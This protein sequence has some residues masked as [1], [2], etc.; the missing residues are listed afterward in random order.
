VV[1]KAAKLMGRLAMEGQFNFIRSIWKFNKVYNADRQFADHQNKVVYQ[2]RP[3]VPHAPLS[4][5]RSEL[6]I[7][8]K[9][10]R[11]GGAEAAVPG[12]A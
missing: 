10:R 7:H 2:I 9:A 6:Y 1:R 8:P 3:P 4:K 5:E 12:A 11:A